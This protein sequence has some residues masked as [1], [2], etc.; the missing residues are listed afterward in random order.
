MA[1]MQPP[2]PVFLAVGAS[3]FLSGT[4]ALLKTLNRIG[5]SASSNMVGSYRDYVVNQRQSHPHGAFMYVHRGHFVNY[6]LDNLDRKC[7]KL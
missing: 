2:G 1:R 7:R 6:A 5:V 4:R 3:T